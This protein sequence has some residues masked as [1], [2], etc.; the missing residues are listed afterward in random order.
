VL[1]ALTGGRAIIFL[2]ILFITPTLI[3][4]CVMLTTKCII[5]EQA[6][7][8]NITK[9]MRISSADNS[10]KNTDRIVH[11]LTVNEPFSIGPEIIS[12][13]VI[14]DTG[15]DLSCGDDDELPVSS[16]F[17]YITKIHPVFEDS[18]RITH[19]ISPVRGISNRY[20]C[21]Y[22]ISSFE[23]TPVSIRELILD[24]LKDDVSGCK[25]FELYGV[26]VILIDAFTLIVRFHACPK[27]VW[28]GII[29]TLSRRAF[30]LVM[31]I[32]RLVLFYIMPVQILAWAAQ[33]SDKFGEL[34]DRANGT[35]LWGY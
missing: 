13:D 32:M 19:G 3:S 23:L 29:S 4:G 30:H 1:G 15:E 9:V 14:F 8:L 18:P 34:Y 28:S 7:G 24:A 31:W 20:I 16:P 22:D 11:K 10:T 12:D 26:E 33:N 17:I 2:R 21:N 5:N 25:N 27:E 35:L 6:M